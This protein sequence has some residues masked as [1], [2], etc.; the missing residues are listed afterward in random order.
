[1]NYALAKRQTVSDHS[2]MILGTAQ[3][4]MDYGIANRTGKPDEQIV[5]DILRVAWEGGIRQ[6]DTAQAYG[7]SEKI[8]GRV[9]SDMGISGQ[10][11]IITKLA[12]HINHY[13]DQDITD[14]IK[15]SIDNLKVTRLYGLMLHREEFL[16][17]LKAG[18]SD[19]LDD[20]IGQC[21][22]EKIGVSV[23]SPAKA[24]TALQFNIIKML[25]VPANICDHRFYENGILSLAKNRGVDIYIRSIFLQGLLLMK[26]D[27]I[28]EKM[29]YAASLLD[30]VESLCRELNLS[31]Q[32][33]TLGYIKQKYPQAFVIVGAETSQ[34]LGDN[35]D[36]WNR[37]QISFITTRVD[38]AFAMVNERII[39]PSLWPH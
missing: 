22:V 18:L 6:F 15:K 2:K 17:L 25:Q 7:E 31:R 36:I 23:Y 29:K 20:L 1:M 13:N 27:E 24:Q 35:I 28:P 16:D 14:A 37:D 26:K 5:H 11:Q 34:Q 19:I 33:L 4:G 32:E 38:K 30:T 10:V 39:N 12:P 9:L 8:L 3:L 21:L